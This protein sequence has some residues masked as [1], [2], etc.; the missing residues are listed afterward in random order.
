MISRKNNNQQNVI[1]TRVLIS[2]GSGPFF[3]L[4]KYFFGSYLKQAHSTSYS[5]TNAK[6]VIRDA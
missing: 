5:N 2:P 6:F 4:V 1:P 3:S